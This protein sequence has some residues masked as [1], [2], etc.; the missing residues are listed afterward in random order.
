MRR[1]ILVF[2]LLCMG[3]VNLFAQLTEIV[4][5]DFRSDGKYYTKDNELY[6]DRIVVKFNAQVVTVPDGKT[7]MARTDVVESYPVKNVL[8]D[9][10]EI[11]GEMELIKVFPDAK[12]GDV[13]RINR[14]TGAPFIS[15]ERSQIFTIKFP[16]PVPLK[17]TLADF[18]A[19]SEV[20]YAEQPVIIA[21][22]EDPNDPYYD[23]GTDPYW[24][25]DKIE[26]SA[27]WDITHGSSS[28][29]I[30]IVDNGTQ[31]DHDDLINKIIGGDGLSD[32]Q[33]SEHG[34]PVASVAAA[35]TNN[36]IDVA[37]I[38]WNTSLYTYRFGGQG[39]ENTTANKI[40]LAAQYCDIINTSWATYEILAQADLV[41]IGCPDPDN[42]SQ[43]DVYSP[44][45]YN[46][47]KDEIEDAVNAGVI[48]VAAA[49]NKTINTDNSGNQAG[50]SWDPLSPPFATYPAKYNGVIAVSGTKIVGG[51]EV[52]ISEYNYGSFIDFSAPSW[53]VWVAT[54]GNLNPELWNGTSFGAPIVSGLVSLII[55]K[56]PNEDVY[57]ILKQTTDKIDQ[58][59][60]PDDANG[61]N[62][63][64]GYGRINMRK[65]LEAVFPDI[66]NN[67]YLSGS[68]GQSP[69]LHWDANTEGDLNGYKIYQKV[70]SGSTTLLTTV[71]FGTTSYIDNGIT[72]GNGRFDP[73]VKYWVSAYDLAGNESAKS[74]SASTKA[75]GVNSRQTPELDLQEIAT[76]EKFTLYPA[77][78]N[79]FNPETNI[80]FYLPEKSK[81]V[82]AI[83]NQLGVRVYYQNQDLNSGMQ[84]FKWNPN[85]VSAGVYYISVSTGIQK[86]TQ[87]LVLL[88]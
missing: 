42:Y 9:K 66:P 21:S 40:H 56:D 38:G 4:N 59:L 32:N 15:N 25:F 47:I 82:I 39:G 83:F 36:L 7:K 50:S 86:L 85:S 22:L 81:V 71:S 62:N 88:K 46:V 58:T 27:G 33:L 51:T 2:I 55:A 8:K 60:Y 13:N 10:A 19:L 26:A 53:D 54:Y 31:Q 5:D 20:A 24:Y 43:V 84:Q 52:F 69:T 74:N 75:G 1:S 18:N 73:I 65:A 41:E 61:W 87:K 48:V 80:S 29:I 16:N 30:G 57:E 28:I 35:Q 23:D 6:V 63:R 70:G 76:P 68:V 72:I 78:P 44:F 17:A 11:Y 37:G 3:T 45:N 14:R 12:W 67:L 34:T 79:P 64:T 49:G 77:Y